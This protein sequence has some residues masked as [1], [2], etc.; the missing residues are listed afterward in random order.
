MRILFFAL[1]LLVALC[2]CQIVPASGDPA[3]NAVNNA[4]DTAEA[5]DSNDVPAVDVIEAGDGAGI[6]ETLDRVNDCAQEG[7]CP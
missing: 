6:G 5:S 3:V 1:L 4:I 7:G 2:A